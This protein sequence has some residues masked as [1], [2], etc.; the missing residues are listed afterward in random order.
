[1]RGAQELDRA[2]TRGIVARAPN[3]LLHRRIAGKRD[4]EGVVA[5]RG[6]REL[7]AAIGSTPA[8]RRFVTKNMDL[9]SGER[10]PT[11]AVDDL[12][13]SAAVEPRAHSDLD[14]ARLASSKRIHLHGLERGPRA[15]GAGEDLAPHA[16]RDE[17]L[18]ATRRVCEQGAVG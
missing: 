5:P 16:L 11:V 4:G 6:G 17:E 15:P 2:R 14:G 7:E 8:R 12:A 9:G 18:D 1:R 10:L 13:P 3:V